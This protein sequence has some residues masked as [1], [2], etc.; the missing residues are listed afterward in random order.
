[1]TLTDTHWQ[2][3]QTAARLGAWAAWRDHFPRERWQSEDSDVAADAATA[4]VRRRLEEWGEPAADRT[5]V[6]TIAL[7][8]YGWH[9]EGCPAYEHPLE[10]EGDTATETD[11]TARDCTCGFRNALKETTG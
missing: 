6:L 8:L 3:L 11:D 7:E 9:T 4:A 5:A 1:M 10:S 2:S